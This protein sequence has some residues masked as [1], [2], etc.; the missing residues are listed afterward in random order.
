MLQRINDL[1]ESRDQEEWRRALADYWEMPSVRRN[2][3]VERFMDRLDP[4]KIRS[5]DSETWCIFLRLYFQ[6]KF[7]GSYLGRRLADLESNEPERLLR[8]R[9]LLF[10]SGPANIRKAVERAGYIKGLGSAG[11]SGLLAVLFPKSFGTVDQFVLKSLRELPTLPERAKLMRMNPKNLTDDDAVL[12][13]KILRAKAEQLNEMF[14]TE[15][16]SPGRST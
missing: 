16:W 6:W 10:T 1:W 11:A 13:I 8:I 9:G 7:K 14:H 15:E 12:L 2:L 4:E 3:D 5:T